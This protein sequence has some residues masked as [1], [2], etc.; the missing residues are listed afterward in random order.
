MTF[1]KVHEG[2]LQYNIDMMSTMAFN[3]DEIFKN[4]KE[5][6]SETGIT[7]PTEFAIHDNSVQV[8]R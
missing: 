4:T 3:S 1:H 2:E 8:A 7:C 5:A 6:P